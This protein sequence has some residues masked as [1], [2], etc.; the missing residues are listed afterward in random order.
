MLPWEYSAN[1]NY[2]LTSIRRDSTFIRIRYDFQ[3]EQKRDFDHLRRLNDFA[4]HFDVKEIYFKG[5]NERNCHC[6][7]LSRYCDNPHVQ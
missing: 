2:D 7:P 3:A 5:I 4:L 1:Y 6:Q